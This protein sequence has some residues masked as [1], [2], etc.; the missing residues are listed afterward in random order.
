LKEIAQRVKELRKAAKLDQGEMAKLL[1][2]KRPAYSKI[3]RGINNILTEHVIKISRH[4]NVSTDWLLFGKEGSSV[5]EQ[6]AFDYSKFGEYK[7]TAKLMF[8]EMCED[9]QFM[10]AMFKNFFHEKLQQKKTVE[11]ENM[12]NNGDG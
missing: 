3:E 2:I 9:E 12:I 6:D 11:I 10:H 5:K 7:S 1:G 4:F 8:T